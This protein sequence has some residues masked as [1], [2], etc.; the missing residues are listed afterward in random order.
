MKIDAITSIALAFAAF[1]AYQFMRPSQPNTRSG[2][3]AD[4]AFSMAKNQREQVGAATYQNNDSIPFFD[5]TG[6]FPLPANVN[7]DSS[8]FFN[9]GGAYRI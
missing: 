8:S 1:A 4:V 2:T 6:V 9:G 3:G 7:S 5:G